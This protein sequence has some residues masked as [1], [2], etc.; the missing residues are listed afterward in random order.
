VAGEA[1]IVGAALGF[2][3]LAAQL[4]NDAIEAS[5][6]KDEATALQKLD[7]AIV[8]FEAGS[9]PAKTA[10]GA[11]RDRVAKRISDKFDHTDA[12]P[13]PGEEPKV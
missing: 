8:R 9:A 7:D 3:Q 5:R 11:V 12:M 10:L 1:A 2:A 6:E 4:V 13:A